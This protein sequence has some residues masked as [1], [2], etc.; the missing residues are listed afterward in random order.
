MTKPVGGKTVQEL[1]AD[2]KRME[3]EAHSSRFHFIPPRK[4]MNPFK[5]AWQ[6]IVSRLPKLK[7]NQNV[8]DTVTG[9]YR[10][11]SDR[12]FDPKGTVVET[13]KKRK[14]K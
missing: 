12:F 10:R 9:R 7:R 8:R 5:D 3:Q 2:R 13:D 11:E 14:D 6:A 1:A 4:P